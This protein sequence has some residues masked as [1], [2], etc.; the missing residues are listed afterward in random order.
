MKELLDSDRVNF[1]VWRFVVLFYLPT[2]A[3]PTATLPGL[4]TAAPA[5]SPTAMVGIRRLL[6]FFF[7]SISTDTSLKPVCL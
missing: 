7:F 2:M 6:T 3:T 5:L 4:W 1:L